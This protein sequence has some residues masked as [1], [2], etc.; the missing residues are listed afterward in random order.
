ML[1]RSLG[2]PL[3]LTSVKEDINVNSVFWHLTSHCLADIRKDEEYSV[4]TNGFHQ[5]TISK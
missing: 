3:L 1:S 5:L 4:G 2:C